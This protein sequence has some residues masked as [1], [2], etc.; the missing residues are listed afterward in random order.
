MRR[1]AWL[2]NVAASGLACAATRAWPQSRPR[3]IGFLGPPVPDVY[4]RQALEE[5]QV[6]LRKLGWADGRL[7]YEVK[8]PGTFESREAAKSHLAVLARELVAAKVDVIVALSDGSAEAANAATS[9][10]PV[11]FL[12]D[13][14]VAGGLVASLAQP[15]GNLTGMTFHIDVL[16]AKRMQLLMQAVP[17]V[18]RV[19]YLSTNSAEGDANARAAAKTLG[20]DLRL[21][22]AQRAD[23]LESAI[24]ARSDLDAWVVEDYFLFASNL[25]RIVEL[26]ARTRK[27]A[28]YSSSDWVRVGGL[29][30]YCD[31]RDGLGRS[32]ARYVDRILRG[33]R[34]AQLPV[35]QPARFVLALNLVTARAIGLSFPQ[36]LLLQADEVIR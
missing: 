17:G 9:T 2:A 26:I 5:L 21:V 23:E 16:T 29:M 8:L 34:P 28:V 35:E 25:K 10:I 18:A 24:V 32:L 36:S 1:R 22:P 13:R 15:G 12:V 31:D 4:G 7:R 20:L 14:P 27:P 3:T 30:S 19:G 33:A 11:V 6:E